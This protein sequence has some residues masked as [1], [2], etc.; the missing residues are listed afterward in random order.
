M[1]AD[2]SLTPAEVPVHEP[3]LLSDIERALRKDEIRA[4][5]DALDAV[6][7][8]HYYVDGDI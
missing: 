6:L 7:V 2:Y 5:L 1:R 8:A 4:R 3:A